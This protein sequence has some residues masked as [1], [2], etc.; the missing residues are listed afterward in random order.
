MYL[1]G[2][3]VYYVTH[4]ALASTSNLTHVK[5]IFIFDVKSNHSL[6]T[7]TEEILQYKIYI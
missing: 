1:Y 3:L 4:F 5:N 7:W 2:L 6:L